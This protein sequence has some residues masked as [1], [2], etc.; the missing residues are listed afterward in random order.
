VNEQHSFFCAGS[1]LT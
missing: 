1:W